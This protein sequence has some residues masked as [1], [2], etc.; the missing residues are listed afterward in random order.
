MAGLLA[1]TGDYTAALE[2]QDVSLSHMRDLVAA[3]PDDPWYRIDLVRALDQKA[4]MLQDPTAETQ[5]GLAILEEMYA[6]GTLPDGFE[7]WIV[8]FRRN[9]GLPTEF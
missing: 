4:M 2:H 1:E 9:L 8:G 3:F 7:E 5:E 6:D